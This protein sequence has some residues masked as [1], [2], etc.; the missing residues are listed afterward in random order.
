M[1]CI[2]VLVE[3]GVAPSKIIFVNVVCCKEGL[4]AIAAA[5]PEVLVVTGGLDPIL[6]EKK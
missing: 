4:E 5:Y 2:K 3:R 1:M 6:N